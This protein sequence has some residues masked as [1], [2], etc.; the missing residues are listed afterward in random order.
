MMTYVFLETA[1]A[2]TAIINIRRV[3]LHDILIIIYKLVV[4][5][6]MQVCWLTNGQL[7]YQRCVAQYD[8]RIMIIIIINDMIMPDIIL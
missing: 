5:S 1:D 2:M 8:L 6:L 4:Q 3:N 7:L